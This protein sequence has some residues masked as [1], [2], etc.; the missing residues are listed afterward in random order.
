MREQ[1]KKESPILSLLGMGGGGTGNAFG[2]VFIADPGQVH[3][4]GA[5]SQSWTVPLGVTE[6]CAVCIGG[7]GGGST[8]SNPGGGG[9]GGGCGGRQMRR[10]VSQMYHR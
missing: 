10:H 1:H 5:G 4:T 3:F 6:I 8:G 2:S 7:G 9:G